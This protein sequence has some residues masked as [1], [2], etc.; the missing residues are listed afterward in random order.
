MGKLFGGF[1][2]VWVLA[3]LLSLGITGATLYFGFQQVTACWVTKD[4]NVCWFY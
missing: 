3:A 4:A 2:V 1:F